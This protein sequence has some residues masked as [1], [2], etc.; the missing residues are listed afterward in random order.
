MSSALVLLLCLGSDVYTTFFERGNAAYAAGDLPAAIQAWEQLAISGVANA[1][2]YYN[3]GCAW[4]HLGEPGWAVLNYERAL[5]L[6]ARFEPAARSLEAVLD[7]M[8]ERRDRPE[9]FTLNGWSPSPVPGLSRPVYRWGL[10][11]LWI[12]LWGI[13]A[14]ALRGGIHR[15]GTRWKAASLAALLLLCA[16]ALLAPDPGRTAAV[17]VAPESEARYGPDA[18]DA[19]R[20][21]LRAG[22]R[23]IVDA[24]EPGWARV[25]TADGLRGWV[26]RSDLAS[27]GPP[28]DVYA[29]RKDPEV[30]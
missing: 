18:R 13:L 11:G 7:G 15:P 20:A 24:R 6:D 1:E 19:V 4:H 22:G 26:P 17:V 30:P 29:T 27:L 23:V 10:A 14:M 3:L 9:G 2:V 8:P 12:L 21:V 16:G 28:F 25:E 5:A